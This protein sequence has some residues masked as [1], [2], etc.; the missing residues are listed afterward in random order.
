MWNSVFV[1]IL[2]LFLNTHTAYS[3]SLGIGGWDL[4]HHS[5]QADNLHTT[6]NGFWWNSPTALYQYRPADNSLQSIQKLNYL[7]DAGIQ[8][9]NIHPDQSRMLV[10]Y[11]SGKI[12]IIENHQTYTLYDWQNNTQLASKKA[13]QISFY[14]DIAYICSAY[15]IISVDL[16]KKEFR[17]I[18]KPF[19]IDRE[20]LAAF[21]Y[22]DSIFAFSQQTL[23]KAALNDPLAD[24]HFWHHTY[25]SDFDHIVFQSPLLLTI[26]SAYI[27]NIHSNGEDTL[28]HSTYGSITDLLYSDEG[29]KA[30]TFE[31][32]Q[33][34]LLHLSSQWELLSAET[35]PASISAIRGFHQWDNTLYI[36]TPNALWHKENN[37]WVSMV[38]NGPQSYPTQQIMVHHDRLFTYSAGSRELLQWSNGAFQKVHLFN[39]SILQYNTLHEKAFPVYINTAHEVFE[40]RA[41]QSVHA[42][43]TEEATIKYTTHDSD[44]RLWIFNLSGSTP[45]KVLE[46][47][48]PLAEGAVPMHID[49]KLNDWKID[50]QGVH[51]M[52]A[53]QQG[54]MVFDSKEFLQNPYNYRV[55]QFLP[56]PGNGNLPHTQVNTIAIDRQ[57]IIW[58]GT[59]NGIAFLPCNAQSVFSEACDFTMPVIEG[60]QSAIRLLAGEKVNA[61]KID[62]GNRKWVATDNGVWLINPHGTAIEAHYHKENSTLISNKVQS[63]D[64]QQREGLV[65]FNTDLGIAVLKASAQQ[66]LGE[67]IQPLVYPNPTPLSYN[68]PIAIRNIPENALVKIT[69]ADGKLI[70]E[71]R[72]TGSQAIWYG[73]NFQKQKV[74]PGVYIALIIDDNSRKTHSV[75][76]VI[77]P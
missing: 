28:F 2:L 42:I 25:I 41:D 14:Q 49:S 24:F 26:D 40:M 35:I 34:H 13:F 27:F 73:L 50:L 16:I 59:N 9:F 57:Q 70:N 44:K 75:K 53:E 58:I 66:L 30:L 60:D 31:N 72:A 38:F 52:A 11:Q 21:I 77:T 23:S 46:N 8:L 33:Y 39:D 3:Q 20:I 76:I 69:T 64:I 5:Y 6:S 48:K 32:Q 1:A 67:A 17:E 56:L 10:V 63:I 68:G 71:V 54:L 15:G 12:D 51:W 47:G 19:N 36:L 62:G 65:Y 61:I 22:N 7:S 29:S 37:Q 18:L 43:F 4:L 45:L 74:S 55:R